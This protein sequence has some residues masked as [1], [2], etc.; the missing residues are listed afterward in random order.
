MVPQAALILVLIMAV[1]DLVVE[2]GEAEVGEAEV[3]VEEVVVE[4]VVFLDPRFS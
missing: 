2:V 3:V 4:V 1:K